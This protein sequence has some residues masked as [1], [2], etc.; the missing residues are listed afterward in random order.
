MYLLG[1][2]P[3]K[4]HSLIIVFFYNITEKL[5]STNAAVFPLFFVSL[6][7]MASEV[8]EG[9]ITTPQQP[10]SNVEEEPMLKVR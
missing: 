9:V 3:V 10:E 6:I 4:K 1:V 8:D 2:R 5:L 7:E